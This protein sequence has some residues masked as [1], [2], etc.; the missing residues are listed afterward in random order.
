MGRTLV[1]LMRAC[2]QIGVALVTAA[3]ACEEPMRVPDAGV[4]DAGVCAS[5]LDCD[6]GLSCNGRERCRPLDPSAGA[7]GCIV[8][9]SCDGGADCDE[10]I[11]ASTVREDAGVCDSD[12][13]GHDA[14]ACGGDDCDD[15]DRARFPGN[16]ERCEGTL[17]DGRPLADHDEDCDPCTV[18]GPVP[19]GD[20]DDDRYVART[21]RNPWLDAAPS[22]CDLAQVNVLDTARVVEGADCDDDPASGPN[23]RPNQAEACGN[24]VDDNCNGAI[25][26]GGTDWYPDCD[27]DGYGARGATAVRECSVPGGRPEGCTSL[28][29]RWSPTH[30]DCH[31]TDD[32]VSP[33]GTE[34][35]DGRDEDCDDQIDDGA[36]D[37]WCN[38]PLRLAPL[39]A[40]TAA[41]ESGAC[42]A[43]SCAGAFLDCDATVSG[44]E[45][46]G[47][48]NY[49][50]CGACGLSCD[51]GEACNSGSCRCGGLGGDCAGN[52]ADSCCG[53]SCVDTTR[54]AAHCGACN[55]RCDP[56]ETCEGSSCRCGGTGPDCAGTTASR[57]CGT[58]CI[59]T[60]NDSQH[61]GGCGLAC[62]PDETCSGSVCR[63]GGVGP[64]C[65][66]TPESTCCGTRCA[67]LGSDAAN[68]GACGVPCVW[69]CS[70]AVCDGVLELASGDGHTCARQESGWLSCW[71]QNDRG[72]VLD[73]TTTLQLA[74]VAV[75]DPGDVI[76]I[77]AAGVRTCV[78]R[79]TGAVACSVDGSLVEV[80]GVIDAVEIAVSDMHAC[81]RRAEGSVAC[82]GENLDGRLGNGTI[83]ASATPVAVL[84]LND[85]VELAVG[86]RHSCARRATGE[87]V[88]WGWGV[89][90][91]LGRASQ[92]SSASPV[93][94]LGLD[95]A[96]EIDA[97]Y[98][99]TCARRASG[100]T[101]CWGDNTHGQ[102]GDGTVQN[103]RLTLTTVL[104]LTDAVELA[105]GG[106]HTCARHS[107]GALS[108]W[109]SNSYGQIGNGT[110]NASQPIATP[111]MDIGDAVEIEAGT[112]FGCA[113]RATGSVWCWGQGGAIGDGT[114]STRSVPTRVLSP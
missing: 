24:D 70:S 79:S 65:A 1:R 76:A 100:A 86:G 90:G 55:R 35:C 92:A 113:R 2:L 82:W 69:A 38:D 110:I 111:V 104:G 5:D 8:P 11:D 47:A 93:T 99:H 102:I 44:C 17:A 58:S 34:T 56:A 37:A 59:D 22:G 87:V 64:D 46:D 40:D 91:Q 97:G 66:G 105:L 63:C 61:C 43:L 106:L 101:V 33:T 83:V 21:C 29:A 112:F 28:T 108:C 26:E 31:D 9:T 114:T 45:V 81:A 54:D 94:V 27:E 85:A 84:G 7:S 18:S 50:N 96:V 98:E 109:G 60:R 15:A 80:A 57:C 62:G 41:C 13:D 10:C 39:H 6:D 3:C 103:L 68:C 51:A 12:R 20:L 71:G 52:A 72:Q 107:G 30:D 75:R 4:P 23:V 67:N 48:L 42:V 89:S 73:G 53:S 36:V 14:I 49:S 74:P 19:D 77:D 32:R 88:C 95:D 25:D 16:P 78:L